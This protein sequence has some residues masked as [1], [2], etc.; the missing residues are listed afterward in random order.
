VLA[1]LPGFLQHVR[2]RVY[3]QGKELGFVPEQR[4]GAARRA[5]AM[6]T[7]LALFVRSQFAR[8][9][10]TLEK[11]YIEELGLG[12]H[13]SGGGRGGSSASHSVNGSGSPDSVARA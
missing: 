6:T 7:G 9:K 10:S 2:S 1:H 5:F 4:P 11:T 13:S 8:S 3:A 12:G